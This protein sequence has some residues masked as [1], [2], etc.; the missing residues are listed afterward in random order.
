M[1]KKMKMRS[2]LIGGFFTLL[3]IVFLGRILWIQGVSASKLLN[4][5]EKRWETDRIVPAERGKILDREGR[6]LAEEVPAYSVSLN[7]KVIYQTGLADDIT[8]GLTEILKDNSDSPNLSDKIKGLATKK[9]AVDPAAAQSNGANAAAD[10]KKDNKK[11]AKKEPK[12][13]DAYLV[14]VE[15]N[16][17]G[18]NIDKAKADEVQQLVKKLQQQLNDKDKKKYGTQ[19]DVGIYLTTGKKRYYPGNSLAAHILGYTNREGKASM[20]IEA[21]LDEQLKGTPGSLSYNSD[22]NGVELVQSK[23]VYVPPVNGNYVKLTIDKNIQYYMENALSKVMDQW[24]PKSLMAIAADPKT[25]E[26][27]GMASYPNYNPNEFWKGGD[28][29]N[30]NVQSQ[31]EPGSTFKL[32]TLAAA[33]EEGV[34]NPGATFKSGSVQV[35]GRKPVYDH[36]KIGWGPITYLEGLKRSSNVAFVNLGYKML[37]VER[38][39]DYI[40]RFGFGKKTGIDL[41]G[42][43]AGQTNLAYEVDYAAAT[44]GQALTATAIQEAA[45]YGAIANGGKLMWPH[46]VKEIIDPKTQQPIQKIEP[47]VVGQPVSAATAKKVGEYL[48]QVVADQV[49]G[50]GKDA[51]IEGYRIAGKT[52]TANKVV[53]GQKGYAAN[54]WVISFAGFAPV[55]DPQFVLIIIADEPE[56]GNN[57][58]LGHYVAAPAFKEIMQNS[59]RYLRIP[60]SKQQAQVAPVQ[61]STQKAVDFGNMTA[62]QAKAAAERAGVD[63]ET[64]GQGAKVVAQYPKAGT[65]IGPYQRVYLAMQAPA[66]IAVPDMKGKALRDALE[67]CALLGI[68]TASTGEGYVVSQ[69]L[70]G[71]GS[72]RVLTLQLQPLGGEIVTPPEEKQVVPEKSE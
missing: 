52:G 68:R 61:T 20:G 66:E 60:S 21:Q 41:Y 40:D 17:E 42:E 1:V 13:E 67:L 32:V 46:V 63:I 56:L 2:L 34:F 33:V 48:E 54:K 12:P 23:S 55:E 3:F 45:A 51:Y 4:E 7:P 64:V 9:R 43:V 39:K 58:L 29:T 57:Y 14:N 27:L 59:L 38:L 37:G 26:I 18:K 24:H 31:Y 15:V 36:N 70:Q 49:K 11:D 72:D 62:A 30:H 50:T 53:P 44:Y 22:K 35:P 69:V 8:A 25:M 65:E 71:E 28:Q 5:A 6:I 10:D 47:K 19:A 16:N